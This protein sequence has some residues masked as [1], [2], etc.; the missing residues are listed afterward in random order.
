MYWK[1]LS[2]VV[3]LVGLVAAQQV[4]AGPECGPC[5]KDECPEEP[6]HCRAGLVLDRCGCCL[7]CGRLEGERCDNRSLPLDPSPGGEFYGRC[8]DHM[9]CLL[10]SEL[11]DLV[12]ISTYSTLCLPYGRS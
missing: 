4:P 6:T 12:H 10:R 8:G 9:A 2:V 7:V 5:S 1:L 11:E 3:V